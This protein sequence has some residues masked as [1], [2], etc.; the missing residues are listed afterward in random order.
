MEHK[1]SMIEWSAATSARK[2]HCFLYLYS[3]WRVLRLCL[4]DQK[5]KHFSCGWSYQAMPVSIP[6]ICNSDWALIMDQRTPTSSRDEPVS[7]KRWPSVIQLLSLRHDFS[8][9]LS[10]SSAL[11]VSLD[12]HTVSQFDFIPL[13]QI[14]WHQSQIIKDCTGKIRQDQ[15][16]NNNISDVLPRYLKASLSKAAPQITIRINTYDDTWLYELLWASKHRLFL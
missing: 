7:W 4:I 8:F 14:F 2:T 11:F 1:Q 9:S 6:L 3:I 12:V 13:A 10:P 5:T 16:L 15:N